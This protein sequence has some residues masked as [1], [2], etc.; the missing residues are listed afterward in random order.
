MSRTE[1]KNAGRGQTR[2]EITGVGLGAW[3]IGASRLSLILSSHVP[4]PCLS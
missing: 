2:L 3:V 4:Q 1:P